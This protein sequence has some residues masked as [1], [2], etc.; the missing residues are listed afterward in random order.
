M[1]KTN[2]IVSGIV[3]L[4]VI[5]YFSYLGLKGA[6]KRENIFL[7]KDKVEIETLAPHRELL[8]SLRYKN[9]TFVFE[10]LPISIQKRLKNEE[11][12]AHQRMQAILKDFLVRFHVAAKE[13]KDPFSVETEKLPPLT[14]ISKKRVGMEKV[15]EIYKKNL[16]VLPK[17]HVPANIKAQIY[18]ELIT[19]DAYDYLVNQ[20]AGVYQTVN[21]NLPE[22]PKVNTEWLITEEFSPSYGSDDAP[23]H[24]I[25]IG[26]YGCTECKNFT[27][28]LGLL[29][30]KYGFDNFKVTF[31]PWTK[32][33]IDA[34]TF[35][36]LTAFCLREQKGD[37]SFWNFH[38]L[39]MNK[40]TTI[41]KMKY[42]DLKTA[43]TFVTEV[44]KSIDIQPDDLQ[45]ILKCSSNLTEDNE[46]LVKMTKA[47]NKLS[48]LPEVYSPMAF[49]N[50]RFLDL[51]GRSLF[52]AVDDK[53]KELIK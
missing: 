3:A 20:L 43:T 48:F 24:L 15:E 39:A 10:E 14:E 4:L 12:R 38:S 6:K 45:S 2:L 7:A 29:I 33:D 51:E 49:L 26:F 8:K 11:L 34:F 40:S 16:D 32:R 25:W 53:M 36:N 23:F 19:Q 27:R 47:K 28:D 37:A 22:S 21:T 17:N 44:M 35:L 41:D 50:G 42:D 52:L 30:Q 9:R 46:L 31:I 5:G 13:A 18:A 1:K